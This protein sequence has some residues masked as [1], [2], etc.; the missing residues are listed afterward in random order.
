[1]KVCGLSA[2]FPYKGVLNGY[3]N[4][5]LFSI[6]TTDIN[7][8]LERKGKASMDYPPMFQYFVFFN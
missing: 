7:N 4:F 5:S 6:C 2:Y 3:Y 1:M 8:I